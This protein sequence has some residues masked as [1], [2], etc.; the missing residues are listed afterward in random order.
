MNIIA[1]ASPRSCK[2]EYDVDFQSI[3]S[4]ILEDLGGK[5]HIFTGIHNEGDFVIP[6]PVGCEFF[7]VDIKDRQWGGTKYEIRF[8]SSYSGDGVF[9]AATYVV[10]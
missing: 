2:V 1:Q 9:Y 10:E 7:V 3:A 6:K 4:V 5:F 8:A